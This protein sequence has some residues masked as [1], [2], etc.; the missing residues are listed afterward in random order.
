MNS[1]ALY[2][3]WSDLWRHPRRTWLNQRQRFQCVQ[4]VG[5]SP[6]GE[7]SGTSGPPAIH[8][9]WEWTLQF[10]TGFTGF[11]E[12]PA[13]LHKPRAA[14]LGGTGVPRSICLP[15]LGTAISCGL[16]P[17]ITVGYK[18]AE[19]VTAQ[20]VWLRAPPREALWPKCLPYWPLPSA[21]NSYITPSLWWGLAVHLE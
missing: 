13:E 11:L 12:T 7:H 16:V 5:A 6:V 2:E 4:K 9:G 10:Q 21:W 8:S 17:R 18:E 3:V 20:V 15:S 19:Q 14:Y 1:R